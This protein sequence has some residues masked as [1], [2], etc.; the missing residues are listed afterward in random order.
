LQLKNG[1]SRFKN[2]SDERSQSF[3]DLFSFAL[4]VRYADRSWLLFCCGE[5]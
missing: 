2:A 3:F 1:G 5:Q 4:F